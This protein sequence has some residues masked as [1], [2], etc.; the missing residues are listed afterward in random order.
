VKAPAQQRLYLSHLGFK[1]P[2]T[3]PATVLASAE[4]SGTAASSR[5][6]NLMHA[7]FGKPAAPRERATESPPSHA[8]HRV[9]RPEGCTDANT[10]EGDATVTVVFGRKQVENKDEN[11]L[12]ILVLKTWATTDISRNADFRACAD[13]AQGSNAADGI[14]SGTPREQC[15]PFVGTEFQPKR[16]DLCILK[17]S[18][19]K[20]RLINA[21]GE[22][23]NFHIHQSKFDVTHFSTPDSPHRSPSRTALQNATLRRTAS[24]PAP[25]FK[26]VDS[27][28]VLPVQI[29]S[30]GRMHHVV[31]FNVRF[32]RQDQVGLF[33][34][35]C[36]I[37]EHEDKGMMNTVTVFE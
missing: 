13:S 4:R 22:A 12:E 28:P 2:D 30:D 24:P 6:P 17:G 25:E 11:K 29:E 21:T 9:E 33:V 7:T 10:V 3:W 20:F 1:F 31:E 37:L 18:T 36:H 16:R 34:F 8:L 23:H 19:I 27:V 26:Q 5:A 14:G 15:K 32:D 35:H